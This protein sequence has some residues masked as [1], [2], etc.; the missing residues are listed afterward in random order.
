MN[1]RRH[2]TVLFMPLAISIRDLRQ[3]VI[4]RLNS[5]SVDIPDDVTVC[6]DKDGDVLDKNIV[7]PSEECQFWPKNPFNKAAMQYT[8]KFS[9]KYMVQARQL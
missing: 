3:I 4:Q 1:D 7:I 5:K 8:G 2:G 9:F 6:S